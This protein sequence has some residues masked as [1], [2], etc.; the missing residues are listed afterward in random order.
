MATVQSTHDTLTSNAAELQDQL[1]KALDDIMTMSGEYQQ[2]L[3]TCSKQA[4]SV[5]E[6]EARCQEMEATAEESDTLAK[7]AVAQ[8][9][10]LRRLVRGRVLY[11]LFQSVCVDDREHTAPRS[12]FESRPPVCEALRPICRRCVTVA[13]VGVGL[14]DSASCSRRSWLRCAKP[15]P[16]LPRRLA[17]QPP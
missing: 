3:A 2:A 5:E 9:R 7:N 8:V 12:Q 11:I 13:R 4:A 17:T 6:L 16:T 14:V 10:S 1:T 15:Q